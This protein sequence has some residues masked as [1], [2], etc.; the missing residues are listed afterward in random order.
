M[1]VASRTRIVTL[2]KWFP[3]NDPLAAKIARLC[4]LRE[5]FLLEMNGVYTAEIKEL[6]GLSK[7]WRRLYFIRNLI[8]TLREIESGIQRLLSAPEFKVLLAGQKPDRQREFEDHTKAMAKGIKV[9]NEVRNDIC[10]HVR[11]AVVQETL[12]ELAGSDVFGFL[13]IGPTMQRT[14]FKFAGELVVQILVRGVPDADKHRV[15][16]EKIKKIADLFQAFG[17]IEGALDIY[18]EGRNLLQRQQR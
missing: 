16:M 3:P 7:E 14:Y 18:M 11:E 12:D 17:L 1:S 15:F 4:I 8:R 2:T 6:D 10:G 13:E 5:D 9:V